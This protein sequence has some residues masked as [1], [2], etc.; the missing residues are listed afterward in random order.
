MT[1]ADDQATTIAWLSSPGAYGGHPVQR[2]DTHIS[3]VFLAGADAFKLK[4][5]VRFDFLD[6]STADLR[7]RRCEDE[8]RLNRRTAPSIYKGVLPIT[9]EGDGT[10]AIDGAGTPLDWVVH[11]Q[12]FDQAQLLDRLAQVGGLSTALMDP[13]ARSI[14]AFHRDAARR[15]DRGGAR[16]LRLV[17]DGN[18]RGLRALHDHVNAR[19]VTRLIDLTRAEFDRVSPVLEDRRQRGFVRE[20]HG[21][22]H[23]GNI[24]LIDGQP[25]L[26]DAIEFN[27]DIAC[28]DVLYDLAFLVMDLRHR[29]LGVHANAL[30]N[31]YLEETGDYG[32]LSLLPV[33]LACRA[34]VRAKIDAA[35]AQVQRDANRRLDLQVEAREYLHEGIRYLHH[36][37]P[38]ALAVGGFSGTGKSTVAAAVAPVILGAP[39]AVLLRSDVIRKQLCGVDRLEKLGPSGYTSDVSA[40]VYAELASRT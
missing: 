8:V 2:V 3:I 29:G 6:F 9:R 25:T 14:A 40:R 31:A 21:D 35:S 30:L 13:L 5:A 16:G 17:V 23:L 33:F 37:A 12:R 15:L 39:G 19:A 27:D 1:D 4:R 7:R 32:G 10:L 38:I 26:F 28:C 20:C 24:V 11:M 18:D 34:A 36:A 22:L